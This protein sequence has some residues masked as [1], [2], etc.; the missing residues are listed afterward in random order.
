MAEYFP[1]TVRSGVLFNKFLNQNAPDK[2]V[3]VMNQE[4]SVAKDY[5]DPDALVARQYF[6]DN[7]DTKTEDVLI[8]EEADNESNTFV[9]ALRYSSK[10]SDDYDAFESF[11]TSSDAYSPTPDK[12]EWQT[13]LYNEGVLFQDDLYTVIAVLKKDD[14]GTFHN[15]FMLRLVDMDEYVDGEP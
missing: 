11:L 5:D 10:Q 7:R 15:G 8:Y 3:R 2:F 12:T 9:Y 13:F 4:A 14:D 6:F 1:N